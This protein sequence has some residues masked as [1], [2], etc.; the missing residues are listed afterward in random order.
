MEP[1]TWNN[2]AIRVK[3]AESVPR[4]LP[5]LLERKKKEHRMHWHHSFEHTTCG[6]E[7]LHTLDRCLQRHWLL[8]ARGVW[9]ALVLFMLAVYGM[10][11]PQ[12]YKL[13]LSLRPE[14]RAGLLHLGFSADFT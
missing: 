4:R 1:V 6:L 13:A 12:S 5:L 7:S 10:G 11:I 9:V 14:T 8:L 3:R 2:R